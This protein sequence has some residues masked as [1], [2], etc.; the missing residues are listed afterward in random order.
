VD[1]VGDFSGN[2]E[3][4]VVYGKVGARACPRGRARALLMARWGARVPASVVNGK[5]GRARY[6]RPL[7]MARWG[8]R[9]THVVWRVRWQ[10]Y[11]PVG[12]YLAV[13]SRPG[14][15]RLGRVSVIFN[16]DSAREYTYMHEAGALRDG[17]T[18]FFN[19]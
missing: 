9:V 16:S 3:P 14:L 11:L 5:V 2:C 18:L 19:E 1:T 10:Y 8:A 7:L 15:L 4:C 6:P 12:L 17:Q 13:R